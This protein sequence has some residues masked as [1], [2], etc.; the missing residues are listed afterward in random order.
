MRRGSGKKEKNPWWSRGIHKAARE[1][2]HSECRWESKSYFHVEGENDV[3]V[4][5]GVAATRATHFFSTYFCLTNWAIVL[6]T[7]AN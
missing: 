2:I 3:V 5:G 1:W 7:R 6:H 4:T